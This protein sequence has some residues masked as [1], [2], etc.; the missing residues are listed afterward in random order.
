MI[1]KTLI[2]KWCEAL[3]ACKTKQGRNWIR[4]ELDGELQIDAVGVLLDIV[5]PDG[6]S[7]PKVWPGAAGK[8]ELKYFAWNSGD[9]YTDISI[10]HELIKLLGVDED[11]RIVIVNLNDRRLMSFSEIADWLEKVYLEKN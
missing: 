7:E 8:K 6:W 2:A 1:N 5:D 3:R 11:F 4:C 9:M 10:P